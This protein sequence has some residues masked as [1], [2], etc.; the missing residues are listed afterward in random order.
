MKNNTQTSLKYLLPYRQKWRMFLGANLR[1]LSRTAT[2][3]L[4]WMDY[5]SEKGNASL[6]CRHFDIPRSTLYYWLKRYDPHDLSS[7]EDRPRKPVNVRTPEVS[8][9]LKSEVIELR[10]TFKGWG[11]VKIQRILL[12]RGKYLGSNSIQR[13]IN[14][15]GLRRIPSKK[16]YY[17]RKRRQHM[18]TVSKEVMK[19][20]G[21]LVYM[22]VKHLYLYPGRK[23]YQFTAIDH[24]T[25]MVSVK[26]F[27]R[28]TSGSG[29]MFLRYIMKSF[30]FRNI[31]YIGSDNGSEF[32]G[33]FDKEL[34]KL[35]I[36]HVFT[37]PRSPKQ[38]PYAERMIRSIIINID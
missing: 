20:P 7:L 36:E 5:Y 15:A 17:K 27:P 22:D 29:K 10:T 24:S 16:K 31:Q 37:T 14:E 38:N 21:G 35:G 12:N 13:I 33:D 34:K 4:K 26:I 18:Y 1:N 23:V 30:P 11:K 25:K 28:I 8:E 3:R 32:L 2:L 19:Q 6:T 9:A